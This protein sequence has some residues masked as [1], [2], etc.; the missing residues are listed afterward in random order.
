MRRR[1]LS[2]ATG[3]QYGSYAL[4]SAGDGA[5]D[6]VDLE[7]MQVPLLAGY[8]LGFG[9]LGLLVQG[10]LSCDFFFG[11]SGRYGSSHERSPATIEDAAFRSVNVSMVVRPQMIYRA[12]DR[13][14]LV[15]GLVWSEQLSGLALEGALDGARMRSVGASFGLVWRLERATY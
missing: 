8:E 10:G 5:N 7:Y 1:H 6:E 9:R 12:T 13:I 14:G 4:R 15:A 11:A 2:V 3:V